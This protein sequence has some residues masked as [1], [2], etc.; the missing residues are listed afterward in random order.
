MTSTAKDPAARSAGDGERLSR[1][2]EYDFVI[3]GAGPNG[4]GISAY[5]S[6]WG[7]KVC[8]LEARPE[9]GGGAENAEPIPGYS[10]DPHA[11]FFYGGAGPALEQLELGRYGFRLSPSSMSA[12]FASDGRYL[13]R[14]G[15]FVQGGSQNAFD[16]VKMLESFGASQDDAKFYVEFMANLQPRLVEF[17]RSVYWTPPYDHRWRV[18]REELPETKIFKE[19]VP[20]W[21]D[22]FLEMSYFEFLEAIG[23]PDPLKCGSLIGAWG[24]G[25]HPYY[26]GMLIPAFGV[27]Q[28]MSVTNSSSPVGGMHA[29]AHAL[30]RCALAHG[31]RI[32]VNAPVSE[33]IVRRAGRRLLD[34]G[35]EDG[36][37]AHG[38]D[39]QQPCEE[40]AQGVLVGGVFHRLR[41]APRRPQPRGREPLGREH[42]GE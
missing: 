8:N 20:I 16:P 37:G 22:A 18:P 12:T 11:S 10:I 19:L 35:G 15:M 9:V 25:P 38:R 4:L 26:R 41:L 5:L 29:L 23:L 42:G 24:N 40:P 2:S 36:L 14:Q 39:L 13:S 7:F 31:A 3:V 6:K 34:A 21:D 32:F 33:V 27:G 17:L 30:A 28:L 1:R